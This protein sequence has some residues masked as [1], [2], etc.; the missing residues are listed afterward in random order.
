MFFLIEV[1]MLPKEPIA[2]FDPF[3]MNNTQEMCQRIEDFG[4]GNLIN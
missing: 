2:I 4:N 1:Y 3:V